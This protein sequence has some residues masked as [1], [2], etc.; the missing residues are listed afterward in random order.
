[1]GED[2]RLRT[3]EH[4]NDAYTWR[5]H[6]I[7]SDDTNDAVDATQH[8]V[9]PAEERATWAKDIHVDFMVSNEPLASNTYP[10]FDTTDKVSLND[11]KTTLERSLDKSD[12]YVTFYSA[13]SSDGK[14]GLIQLDWLNDPATHADD[15]SAYGLDPAWKN[16]V[17]DVYDNKVL[18]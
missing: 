9:V 18:K 8:W 6:T 11:M 14:G 13:S 16:M 17:Q 7:A 5:K 1:M 3:E 2:Y 4:F 15:G 12:K 10:Q